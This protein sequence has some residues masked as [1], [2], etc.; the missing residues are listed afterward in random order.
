MVDDMPPD[1]E[2]VLELPPDADADVGILASEIKRRRALALPPAPQQEPCRATSS[3]AT[4]R[5]AASS[6]TTERGVKA[7]K[8]PMTAA[9]VAK[10][11]VKLK[12]LAAIREVLTD[13]HEFVEVFS[14]PRVAPWLAALGVD[15]TLSIDILH[16]WDLTSPLTRRL[17]IEYFTRHKPSVAMLSPPCTTF[18]S[19]QRL[20]VGKIK[21]H[22]LQAAKEAEGRLLSQLA[23]KIADVQVASGRAFC[24]EHPSTATS[25]SEPCLMSLLKRPGVQA[26]QFDQCMFGLRAESGCAVLQS[27]PEGGLGRSIA[28][29]SSSQFTL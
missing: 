19:L 13:R 22:T 14:P 18:S 17:L 1:A 15:R 25:F 21:D 9:I 20:S 27:T 12:P 28:R 26:V 4:K 3:T 2:P 16:G 7:D 23:T 8:F 5:P 29:A 6:T 11:N 10:H 24:F